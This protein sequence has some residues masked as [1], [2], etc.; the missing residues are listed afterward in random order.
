[1]ATKLV[2][3]PRQQ[4]SY[5]APRQDRNLAAGLT[6]NSKC[7]VRDVFLW[8]ACSCC[9]GGP[10]DGS[11][12]GSGRSDRGGGNGAEQMIP[13]LDHDVDGDGP[14]MFEEPVCCSA[15]GDGL[16]P[17]QHGQPRGGMEREGD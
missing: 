12:R 8:L 6:S 14:Q 17:C 10:V 13:V 1:M 5:A 15:S 11:A 3:G 2:G 16:A 9:E 4:G 7:P